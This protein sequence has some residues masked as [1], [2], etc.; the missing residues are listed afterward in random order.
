[1]S[2]KKASHVLPPE[3]LVQVQEYVDGEY[4]YIPRL[5]RKRKDWGEGTNTRREL[6]ERNEQI[7]QDFLSG[8]SPAQLAEIY[9][10]SRKSIQRIIARMKQK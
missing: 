1:M 4:L 7:Y 6:R 5:S 3:L 8:K 2:Y 9:F 10:L